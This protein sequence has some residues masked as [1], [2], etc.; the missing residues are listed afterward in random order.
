MQRLFKNCNIA[1][2]ILEVE[3]TNFWMGLL[4]ALLD[5]YCPQEPFA[6]SKIEMTLHVN[7]ITALRPR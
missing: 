7:S 6:D 4:L 5:R 3:P 2:K 1:S